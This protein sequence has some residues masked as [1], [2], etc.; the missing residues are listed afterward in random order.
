MTQIYLF[1]WGDTLMVDDPRQPG[2][3]KDWP[4]VVAV[5]GARQVLSVLS[6]RAQIYIAS[7]AKDS[8]AR[9]IRAALM[10]VGLDGY[11]RACFCPATLGYGKGEAGFLPAVLVR[12]GVMPDQVTMVGDNYAKDICP[13][14]AVGMQAIWFNPEGRL[15]PDPD[16]RQVQQLVAL[17]K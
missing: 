9:D 17:L 8:D 13:A 16:V 14:R 15:A 4:Q 2:K 6:E 11:I 10:R 7:G 1:D 5:E 12:L 3:M